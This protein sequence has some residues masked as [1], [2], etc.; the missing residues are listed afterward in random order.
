MPLRTRSQRSRPRAPGCLRAAALWLPCALC[1]L[2]ARAPARAQA[3]EGGAA[4]VASP[5]ALVERLHRELSGTLAIL[6]SYD[7]LYAL[8]LSG[9]RKQLVPGRIFDVVVDRRSD[10]IWY[11]REHEGGRYDL[12]LID[13][14]APQPDPQ[15]VVL[16][17]KLSLLQSPRIHYKSPVEELPQQGGPSLYVLLAADGPGLA[18]EVDD[19]GP[20]HRGVCLRKRR[21]RCLDAAPAPGCPRLTA[22]G[23]A[24][25]PQLVQRAAGRRLLLPRPRPP[26]ARPQRIAASPPV[27]CCARCGEALPVPGCRYLAVY[28]MVYDDCCHVIP[29]LY[30]PQEQKYIHPQKGEHSSTP[31]RNGW[32]LF[33]RAEVCAGGEGYVMDGRLHDFDRG[34][35][36][37]GG[38]ASGGG[39]LDGGWFFVG[40][41]LS[42]GCGE[43]A[44]CTGG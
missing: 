40:A 1:A 25:L 18:I 5:P 8:S 44:G 21:V 3:T 23:R 19:C 26:A 27:G 10:V 34:E 36:P 16:V 24:L 28:A 14:R 20:R 32:A 35:L 4:G 15:P 37:W 17:Q 33:G 42:G 43:C 2:A 13:L 22:A 30:D 31:F 9:Q 7:G 38:P 6:G 11:R 12:E 29:Q 41:E 39:C